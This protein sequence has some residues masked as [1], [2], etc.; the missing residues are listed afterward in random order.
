MSQPRAGDEEVVASVPT[1]PGASIRVWDA[2][3]EIGDNGGD[4]VALT[5]PLVLGETIRVMTQ[6]GGCR[7]SGH[8][9]YV[10]Q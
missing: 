7:A 9:E 6:L 2:S 1:I 5:R 8:Y 3:A 4:R 10:V